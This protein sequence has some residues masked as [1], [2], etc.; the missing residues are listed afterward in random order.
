MG[1]FCISWV[2]I[3]ERK[4]I[5]NSAFKLTLEILS[6]SINLNFFFSLKDVSHICNEKLEDLIQSFAEHSQ[7]KE[8]DDRE[9]DSHEDLLEDVDNDYKI[10]EHELCDECEVHQFQP[11][12]V[13]DQEMIHKDAIESKGIGLRRRNRYEWNLYM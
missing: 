12:V 1:N 13:E 6:L 7:E 10:E 8:M 9:D 3:K 5:K 11:D 4:Q 2:L